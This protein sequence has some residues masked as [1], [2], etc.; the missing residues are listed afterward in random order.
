MS[1]ELKHAVEV[2]NF[3]PAYYTNL[4]PEWNGDKTLEQSIIDKKEFWDLRLSKF[5]TGAE[6]R[7]RG[8]YLPHQLIIQRL[9]SGKTLYDEIFLFHQPGTG[10]T[11]GTVAVIE[12][13]REEY[14]DLNRAVIL[15]PGDTLIMNY[16]DQLVFTCTDGKYIPRNYSILTEEQKVRRLKKA[17]SDFYTFA[18][19][20]TFADELQKMTNDS[21]LKTFNN[22]IFV[23]DEV[24]NLKPGEVFK[25]TEPYAEIRKLFQ[26]LPNRKI[27]IASATP[28]KDTPNQI[29]D[30][31]NLIVPAAEELPTG[32]DFNASYMHTVDVDGKSFL[33]LD[34]NRATA[35]SDKIRG[36]ISYLRNSPSTVEK[37]F[38]GRYF[39]GLK[40]LTTEAIDMHPNQMRA[41]NVAF[42]MD[43]AT[44]PQSGTIKRKFWQNSIDASLMVFPDGS[45]GSKGFEK[46]V[47]ERKSSN[48][49]RAKFTL[50]PEFTNLFKGSLK[51]KLERLY[52]LSAKYASII[53]SLTPL[54]DSPEE[55]SKLRR[56]TFIYN[57]LVQ[58][59]GA[60]VLGLLLQLFG[61]S[62][63]EGRDTTPGRRYALFAANFSTRS[64]ISR[65]LQLFNSP[66]NKEGRFVQVIIGS[67]KVSEGISF[68]NVTEIHIAT[69]HWNSSKIEQAIGRGIRYGSHRM[70]G[71]DVVVRI[72]QYV[73]AVEDSNVEEFDKIKSIDA[74]MYIISEN[75]DISIKSVE[76][77]C[78]ESAIDCELMKE[79]NIRETGAGS[80]DCDYEA[81]E[82]ECRN[83]DAENR[84]EDVSTFDAYYARDAK[85]DIREV[86]T[87][88][89]KQR[90]W[91]SFRE[92][93]RKT[94]LKDLSFMIFAQTL[95]EMIMENTAVRNNRGMWGWIRESGNVIYL[96]PTIGTESTFLDGYYLHDPITASITPFKRLEFNLITKN[97]D[98]IMQSLINVNNIDGF[99]QRLST[100]PQ[101]VQAI[102]LEQSVIAR[103]A[104]I[105]QLAEWRNNIVLQYFDKYMF[106]MDG[107]TIHTLLPVYRFYTPGDQQ[108]R[109]C[110]QAMQAEIQ[111]RREQARREVRANP[112]GY[113]G[114]WSRD[115]RSGQHVF[116]IQNTTEEAMT[117]K[118]QTARSRGSVC[119]NMNKKDLVP[120]MLALD[121]TATEEEIRKAGLLGKTNAEILE[122]IANDPSKGRETTR[123]ETILKE[124]LT[125]NEI[126]ELTNLQ[127]QSVLVWI[128]KSK[129]EIC[130]ALQRKFQE[131][132]WIIDED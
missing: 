55:Q 12:N 2:E 46:Y 31:M 8:Q 4:L 24:H 30:V 54:D 77:V 17:V 62:K 103:Q 45:W 16:I 82:Y 121:L 20:R 97:I 80:R 125:Q 49:A 23:I 47:I 102:L 116:K 74:R 41:Y 107:R 112:S 124:G 126:N 9:L 69:P 128:D 25:G 130:S 127:L 99:R 58:G 117:K 37:L 57:S 71:D 32:L 40:H 56:N 109:D 92:I 85:S 105:T 52:T 131:R 44:Q 101:E 35:L 79:R 10:K 66:E 28:M 15:T 3:I 21:K 53:E 95:A 42:A 76:R 50:S 38:V 18:T 13:C 111:R 1:S 6:N 11:C 89:L 48:K 70:L 83:V 19:F 96:S 110:S 78:M 60:I 43:T 65:T 72:H 26:L 7:R 118:K 98:Q 75:K 14:V 34:P 113:T 94:P 51:D 132:G 84:H 39:Y 108:W 100:V 129:P 22:T 61:F 90:D 36:R 114:L 64:E 59:S 104:N 33:K 29:A 123:R 73:A 120:V 63:S 93:R 67:S 122:I 115:A 106:Q 5:D 27:I 68:Q 88:A 86:I 119:I 91:V 81:C 87:D